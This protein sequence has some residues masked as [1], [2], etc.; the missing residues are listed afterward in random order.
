MLDALRHGNAF[1]GSFLPVVDTLTIL[2]VTQ[3][4]GTRD[5][6]VWTKSTAMTSPGGGGASSSH[7]EMKAVIAQRL[8]ESG[9]KERLKEHLRARLV[10]CGWRDQLRVEAK[11]VVRERGLERVRLED[12]VRDITPKGR[13]LVPDAVKREL[14]AKIKEFLAQQQNI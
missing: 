4:K 2:P 7:S 8:A 3:R 10:E 13:A 6:T 1:L 5:S 12:L 9:E 11:E 14:L